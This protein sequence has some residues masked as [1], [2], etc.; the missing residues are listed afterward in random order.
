MKA[1]VTTTINK[2]TPALIRFAKKKDWLLIVVGDKKTPHEEYERMNVVYL[3]PELQEK[4]YKRLSKAIGWNCIQRR[5]IGYVEAYNLG[6]EIIASVDDDNIPTSDW[7]EN[8]QLGKTI[9]VRSYLTEQP[10]LDPLGALGYPFWHRGFPVQLIHERDYR[11]MIDVEIRVMVEASLWNGN[12]D[13]DAMARI[14]MNDPVV[15]MTPFQPFT[16]N[17][18][19]PFNSQNTFFTREAIKD[20]Y[21]RRN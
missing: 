19:M 21:R 18:I 12:P 3:S 7:G 20:Y 16:S 15:N 1:I 9:T 14:T 2:P 5:A 10:V 13:I 8:L 11:E 17:T 4:K 6:A